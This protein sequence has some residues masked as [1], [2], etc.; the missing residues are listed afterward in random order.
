MTV[1]T[2]LAAA[3]LS[4]LATPASA[5]ISLAAGPGAMFTSFSPAHT[6]TATGALTATDTSGA[7]T[8]QV[9]D[10][11]SV[12]GHMVAAATGCGG[13]DS[14]LANAL[15]VNVTSGLGANFIS[16]GVTTISGSPATVAYATAQV[17]T[18]S[19][20]TT[21]YSQLIPATE[22]MLT[23]CVYTLTATYTLQ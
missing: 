17:L 7:W 13:S 23:G 21:N 10:N 8:L 12:G 6:A 1:G 11:G 19:V 9:Q 15:T 3:V 20:L 2:A 4:A 18:A 14:Q 5:L 22:V 16:S